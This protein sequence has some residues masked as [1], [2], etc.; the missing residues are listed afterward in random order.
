MNFYKIIKK[1]LVYFLIILIFQVP[2]G[3]HFFY[4][5]FIILN[6]YKKWILR[7]S[8]LILL[9]G[10]TIKPQQKIMSDFPGKI[11]E[12]SSAPFFFCGKTIFFEFFKKNVEFFPNEIDVLNDFEDNRAHGKRFLC[13]LNKLLLLSKFLSVV[14][15]STLLL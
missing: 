15:A 5:N 8:I 3:D 4:L 1:K 14:D 9:L 10:N 7:L 2:I 12:V 6:K 13:E 11:V